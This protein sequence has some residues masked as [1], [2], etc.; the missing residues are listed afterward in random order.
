[1]KLKLTL[2]ILVLALAVIACGNGGSG[3][4]GCGTLVTIC[5]SSEH[6]VMAGVKSLSQSVKGDTRYFK[7]WDCATEQWVRS[8]VSADCTLRIR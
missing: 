3:S 6:I 8:S 1:M 4:F 7:F 2:V 5:D